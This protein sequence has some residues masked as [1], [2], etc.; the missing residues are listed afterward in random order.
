MIRRPL[1]SIAIGTTLL[2]LAAAAWAV[3]TPVHDWI[4]A[5]PFGG[6]ATTI[7]IDPENPQVVLAGALNSL[8]F[9]SRDAGASWNLTKF[10]KRNL[11]EVSSILVDPADSK[12]YLAGIIAAGGGGLL[13]SHDG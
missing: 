5:G 11:S 13:E 8:L 2:T 9:E 10:P 3:S 4:I 12:H 7:A 6:T 1:T